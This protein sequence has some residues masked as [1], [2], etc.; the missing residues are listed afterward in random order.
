M[1]AC[2]ISGS[3]CVSIQPYLRLQELAKFRVEEGP[4]KQDQMEEALTGLRRRANSCAASGG[5]LLFA[6]HAGAFHKIDDMLRSGRLVSTVRGFAATLQ[7]HSRS[8]VMSKQEES[9][10]CSLQRISS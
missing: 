5:A 6:H 10:V 9:Q 7:I 1:P 2:F 4:N 3:V 8:E